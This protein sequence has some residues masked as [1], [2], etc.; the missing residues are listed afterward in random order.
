MHVCK[1]ES[2]DGS[3]WTEPAHAPYLRPSFFIFVRFRAKNELSP[4]VG[5]TH[6]YLESPGYATGDWLGVTTD[7]SRLHTYNAYSVCVC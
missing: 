1:N 7:P 2:C 5:F 3:R 6:R 4:P